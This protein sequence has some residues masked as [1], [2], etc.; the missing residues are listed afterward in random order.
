MFKFVE[1]RP[2]EARRGHRFAF[3]AEEAQTAE[4]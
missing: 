3:R 4:K 2:Y 1:V